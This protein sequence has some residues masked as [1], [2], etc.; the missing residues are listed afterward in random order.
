MTPFELMD[1]TLMDSDLAEDGVY[2]SDT[3]TPIRCA[4]YYSQTPF[5]QGYEFTISTDKVEILVYKPEGFEYKIKD[6]IRFKNV[7]YTI[8]GVISDDGSV[9][10]FSVLK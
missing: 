8:D 9:V 2:I 3:E 10:I 7:L 6:K 1:N 4:F 5:Y